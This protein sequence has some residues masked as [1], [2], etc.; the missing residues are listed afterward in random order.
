MGK[1]HCMIGGVKDGILA[2]IIKQLL[3]SNEI[4]IHEVTTGLDEI[5][6]ADY[7]DLNYLILDMTDKTLPS[8]YCD[9]FDTNRNLIVIELLNNG[10]SLGIY[11][12]DVNEDDLERILKLR[13]L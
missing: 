3:V 10:R 6:P 8:N 4:N 2:D 7:A 11:V 9:F 13:N 12:D 1:S 5:S